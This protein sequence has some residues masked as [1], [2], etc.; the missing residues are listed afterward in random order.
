MKPQTGTLIAVCLDPY[1][2]VCTF[3]A[4]DGKCPKCGEAGEQLNSLAVQGVGKPTV[5]S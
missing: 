4:T 1:C 5:R 3:V 2:R